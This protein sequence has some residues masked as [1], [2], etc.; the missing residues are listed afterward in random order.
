MLCAYN[1]LLQ[2]IKKFKHHFNQC[3]TGGIIAEPL[4]GGQ[5]E[6]FESSVSHGYRD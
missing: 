1:F 3:G 2:L 6:V 5:V 4:Q